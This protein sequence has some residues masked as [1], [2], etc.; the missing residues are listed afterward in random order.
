MKCSQVTDY[1]SEDGFFTNWRRRCQLKLRRPERRIIMLPAKLWYTYINL[2]GDLKGD[3][4][5]LPAAL[6]EKDRK[7]ALTQF[8]GVSFLDLFNMLETVIKI[9]RPM[10]KKIADYRRF[11]YALGLELE[12]KRTLNECELEAIK[13]AIVEMLD[14]A[15]EETIE[16]LHREDV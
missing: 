2:K 13:E 4:G 15:V 8:R 11:L 7:I 9:R 14:E 12:N 3:S 1:P 5:R 16:G 10:E 6:P